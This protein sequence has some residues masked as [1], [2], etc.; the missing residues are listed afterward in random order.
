MTM[1]SPHHHEQGFTLIEMIVIL[2]IVG[3]ISGFALPSFLSFNK[4]L[5]NGTSQF[6]SQL[7]LIRSKAISSGQAYRIRPAFP[8]RSNYAGS[9]SFPGVPRNF[10]AEYAANCQVNKYGQGLAA[11]GTAGGVTYAN[12]TPNGWMRASQLD[13]DLPEAIGIDNR[14]VQYLG[15]PR[16]EIVIDGGQTSA[17]TLNGNRTPQGTVAVPMTLASNPTGANSVTFDPIFNWSICFDN[18]GL[19]YISQL[20]QTPGSTPTTL[21]LLLRNY[22]GSGRAANSLITISGIGQ[23]QVAT[24]DNSGNNILLNNGNPVY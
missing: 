24:K 1:R 16:S 10:I 3:I 19:S 6:T 20:D 23:V 18:R 15:Q 14:T 21:T 8:T 11:G 17:I 22:Q 13:T 2:V 7:S 4:P 12:G 9:A 5:R